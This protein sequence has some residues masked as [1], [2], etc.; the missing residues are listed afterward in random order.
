MACVWRLKNC[1]KLSVFCW[2]EPCETDWRI[3]SEMNTM[4]TTT[5]ANS[6]TSRCTTRLYYDLLTTPKPYRSP[7]KKDQTKSKSICIFITSYFP[8]LLN[9][10]VYLSKYFWAH[11]W[12]ILCESL[13]NLI[14]CFLHSN[15]LVG[16][17]RLLE[18]ES[19]ILFSLFL[20]DA[21]PNQFC[22]DCIK[23]MKDSN[24]LVQFEWDS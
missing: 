21:I 6:I 11:C 1:L 9:K 2:M 10:I 16:W 4:S 7:K 22:R 19:P 13:S 15:I 23:R 18:K 17:I 3:L 8:T 5:M 14:L 20:P 12:D 24:E